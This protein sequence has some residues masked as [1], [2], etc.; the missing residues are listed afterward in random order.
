MKRHWVKKSEIQSRLIDF[1][2][3]ESGAFAALAALLFVVFLTFGAL[4]VDYAHMVSVQN[5]LQNAADA[6]AF[7]GAEALRQYTGNL[8]SWTTGWTATQDTAAQAAASSG[9]DGEKLQDGLDNGEPGLQVQAQA[10]YWRFTTKQFYPYNNPP[11]PLQAGTDVAAM[12]VQITKTVNMFFAPIFK[13]L[14]KNVSATAVAMPK[15]AANWSILETGNGNLTL[16]SNIN[17]NRDVGDN[18]SGWFTLNSNV[19]VQGKVYLNT[20]TGLTNNG[21][22]AKGGIEQD[23]GSNSILAQAVQDAQSAYNRLTGLANNLGTQAIQLNSNQTLIIKG[24]STVN[25]LDLTSLLMNSGCTLTL[26]GTSS[27]SFVVRVSGTFILNSNSNVNLSGGLTA[28]NVTFVDT[29]TSGVIINSNCTM[30]GSI[31]S[32]NSSVTLNSNA[33]LNGALVSGKDIILNSNIVV[34]PPQTFLPSTGHGTALVN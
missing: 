20:K 14:T 26:N 21:G 18:G 7:S 29:G 30:N 34:T 24:T 27:M 23:A 28:G 11:N 15:P 19:T 1:M 16:N 33:T 6:G 22:V 5:E 8:S 13:V 12:Q 32:P 25:V 2:A 4:V 10:G 17:V 3:N 31:L 9:A